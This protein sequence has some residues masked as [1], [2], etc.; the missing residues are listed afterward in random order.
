MCGRPPGHARRIFRECTGAGA[1]FLKIK[2]NVGD[3][4]VGRVKIRMPQALAPL[5]G[6]TGLATKM[7]RNQVGLGDPE[8]SGS[9]VPLNAAGDR[10]W[11]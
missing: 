6:V 3:R 9:C 10:L 11:A 5:T 2:R 1:I 8:L 4:C 7:L